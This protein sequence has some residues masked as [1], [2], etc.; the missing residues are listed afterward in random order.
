VASR[1][2]KWDLVSAIAPSAD[3]RFDVQRQIVIGGALWDLAVV[4]PLALPFTAG[5]ELGLLNQ[6]AAMLGITGEIPE[7]AAGHLLFVNMA[8]CAGLVWI[9]YRL[10]AYSPAFLRA[11]LWI[12]G[13]FVALLA[14][15]AVASPVA[16]IAG[17][18]AATE[19]L[20]AAI[21][22]WGLWRARNAAPPV[23]SDIERVRRVA[24]TSGL[25][26]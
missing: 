24:G 21:C 19:A 22:C 6:V 3:Q 10:F 26:A 13:V 14:W 12:R 18:F 15:Y 2:R 17:I 7:M 16:A 4:A 20:W 25:S 11:D 23:A 9:A 8:G 1:K 5:L